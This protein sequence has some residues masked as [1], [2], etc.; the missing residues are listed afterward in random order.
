MAAVLLFAHW[1]VDQIDLATAGT[2]PPLRD[3]A[4]DRSLLLGVAWTA[5]MKWSTQILSWAST[6][7]V[8]RLLTPTDYGLFGMAMVFQGFLAPIYDLGIGAAIIQRRDLTEDEIAR[9]GSLTLL[10]GAGFAVLTIALAPPIA[11]FYR[12]PAVRWILVVLALASAIAS[13]QILPR[14]I[15]ARRMQFRTIALIDGVGAL[16]QTIVTVALALAGYRYKALVYGAAF[17]AVVSTGVALAAASHRYAW[18]RRPAQLRGAMSYGWHVALS[19]IGWYI[20]TNADFAVV[21]RV[22]GKAALGAYSFGWTIATIPV[23][24]VA[25]LVG[26]VIP[27]VFASIQDNVPAMR[28]YCLGI[29]EGLAFVVLPLAVGLAVTA[30]DFVRV[31]LGDR[32]SGAIGPLRLLAFYG[33]FRSLATVVSP[34]LVATGHARRNLQYT[35]LA[36]AVLPPLFYVGTRWGPAGVAAAWMVG[37]PLVSLPAYAFTLRLLDTSAAAYL[38][39]L[40]PALSASIVMAGTILLTRL[41]AAEWPVGARFAAETL[42]GA[43]TYAGVVLALHRRRLEV[44][45]ALLRA[46]RGGAEGDG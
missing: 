42:V 23:D 9:L 11:A 44:F 6:L 13:F 33:G 40:W 25:S 36:T 22:L 24:R 17:S 18:P 15:L 41:A 45:R 32:W 26:R 30:D 38:R 7:L 29:T 19:R 12:E 21:G 3:K 28:R 16:S 37:F 35:L 20:Y 27:S 14:T 1:M 2:T 8:A 10:Y 39:A 5:G 31:V 34:V 46:A 4:L 43:L